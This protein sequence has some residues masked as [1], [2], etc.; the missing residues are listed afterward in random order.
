VEIEKEVSFKCCF[1]DWTVTHKQ[2]RIFP[3]VDQAAESSSIAT[4]T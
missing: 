2:T 1:I 4:Y 3:S